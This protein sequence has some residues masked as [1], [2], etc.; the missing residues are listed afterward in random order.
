MIE[1]KKHERSWS[2]VHDIRQIDK[3]IW[4]NG[5]TPNQSKK[6]PKWIKMHHIKVYIGISKIPRDNLPIGGRGT[7]GRVWRRIQGRGYYNINNQHNIS[8]ARYQNNRAEFIFYPHTYGRHQSITYDNVKGD[9]LQH[10]KKS[11]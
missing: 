10:I 11:Y 5:Y 2:K 1:D 6:V 3:R 7:Q 4:V 9:T 8:G